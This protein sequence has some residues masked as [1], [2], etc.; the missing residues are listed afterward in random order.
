MNPASRIAQSGM[1]N[2]TQIDASQTRDSELARVLDAYLAAMEAGQ[3]IEP[4]ALAAAH[5]EIAERILACL[6]VL[7]VAGQVEG[8]PRAATG[9][10]AALGVGPENCLGDFLI[11]RVIGRGGM[12]IVFEAEQVSLKRR[13][14]LK[15]LPFAAAL[16]PQQLRRFEIEAQA[17]AQL[18]HTNIVPIFSVGCERGVHY[19]AMQY[20]EGQTLAALIND[21]RHIAGLSAAP[22]STPAS[23]S[24]SL[25]EE[26][27]SGRL[28]P[29]PVSP[30]GER[31][32]ESQLRGPEKAHD[33]ADPCAEAANTAPRPHGERS[34]EGRV[35]GS[36]ASLGPSDFSSEAANT[37]TRPHGERSAEGRVR[38]HDASRASRPRADGTDGSAPVPNAERLAETDPTSSVILP[39]RRHS[40]PG[41]EGR[42]S[43]STITAQRSPHARPAGTISRAYFRTA[44]N[45][46]LQAAEALDHAHRQGIIH[47]DVKPANLLVDV[48]GNLWITD[49]GLARMQS[50]SSLTMTGDIIGTLRY[51]S[52][53]QAAP[54]RAIVDH[55]TDVYSL[56]ATLHELLTLHPAHEGTDRAELLRS[57]T[58]AEPTPPRHWNP[59]IPRDLETIVLKA[60]AR[61]VQ[62]RYPTAL[63]LADDLRRFLEDR[64]IKAR[65]PSLWKRAVKWG[66]RHKAIVAT[67]FLALGLIV[68]GT[69]IAAQVSHS[70]RLA[71]VARHASYVD[72]VR[73]AFHLA[74]QDSLSEAINLLARH[75]PAQGED[76]ERS[77]PWYYLWHLCH[78]LRGKILLGHEGEVYHVEYSPDSK[79]LASCGQDGMIRLWEAATGALQRK[80]RAH[81]ETNYATF[82]PDGK[83]LATGGDDGAVRL[84]ETETGKLL[85]ELGRH[86][87]WTVCVLFSAD[88][89]RVISGSRDG[90]LK[91][92]EVATG[93]GRALPSPIRSIGGMAISPD[94]H[95]LVVG[96][97]GD[98]V[99]FCDPDSGA[100][101]RSLDVGTQVQS[102]A[103]SHDG[104]LI[105]TAGAN[106]RAVVWDL[107]TGRQKALFDSNLGGVEC[108]AFSPDDR[109]LAASNRDGTVKLW[110]FREGRLRRVYRRYAS[111][112]QGHQDRVWCVAFSPDGRNYA[113]CGRNAEIEVRALALGQQTW[114]HIAGEKIRSIAVSPDGQQATVLATSGAD[115]TLAAVDVTHDQIVSQ[116]LIQDTAPII[117]ADLSVDGALLATATRTDAVTLWSARTFTRQRQVL[118]PGLGSDPQ[119]Q[120][121]LHQQ[122]LFSPDGSLLAMERPGQGFLFWNTVTGEEHRSPPLYGALATFLPDS[123]SVLL[124]HDA[125][126]IHWSVSAGRSSHVGRGDKLMYEISPSI[127]H[128]GKL[129][130]N[131]GRDGVIRLYDTTDLEHRASLLGHRENVIATAWSPDGKVLASNS[132]DHTVRLWDVATRQEFGIV[133]ELTLYHS[134]TFSANGSTLAAY[135]S[136]GTDE[137]PC[138]VAAWRAP[139]DDGP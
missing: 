33:L 28:A 31:L 75:R 19:Y 130:A 41:E 43:D 56:G 134:L 107:E 60:L 25:A 137:F 58:V 27:L 49:F 90:S 89:R 42:D 45:L 86:R 2:G 48:R 20:I 95:T 100:I 72:D 22:P 109:S 52:P 94:G 135:R 35:R 103:F 78:S 128:D 92:W 98:S 102:V 4:T 12:G 85:R 37:P 1:A 62:A 84:W 30:A 121:K 127:S 82:S 110:D 63:D 91:S 117:A 113:S 18:H 46:A 15:V 24:V 51:T 104:K 81:D 9:P 125:G 6:S 55:R 26:L 93:A 99:K 7:R 114:V 36:E 13:V 38:G 17:A 53:E 23:A 66:R 61:D 5:P 87:D 67:T 123:D 64:P 39:A 131:G 136:F 65:R 47:R 40:P 8:E 105:A 138:A 79:I 14:A 34:A 70:R 96:G 112:P 111:S 108:V 44:A 106:E 3:A 129:I 16:D 29:T 69:I 83:A 124:W 76:D 21:L 80:W 74:R 118:V 11:L 50:D 116:R 122:F 101:K 88:G 32:A 126:L 57:L 132:N 115:A 77:F 54:G 10:D 71:A 59:A 119:I 73:Q 139:R 97:T 120:F 68:S 133:E